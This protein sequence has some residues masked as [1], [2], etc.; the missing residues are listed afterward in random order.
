MA[1]KGTL[2]LASDFNAL[3]SNVASVLGAGSGTYGYGQSVTSSQVSTNGRITVAQWANLRNDLLKCVQHQTNVDYTGT[4]TSPTTSTKLTSTIY[5]SYKTVSDYIGPNR[6]TLPAGQATRA[7]LN[8]AQRTASWNGTISHVVVVNFTESTLYPGNYNSRFFFNAG[9]KIE[10]TVTKTT[11]SGGSKNQSWDAL[12]SSIGTI[13]FD[14][15]TTTVSGSGTGSTIGFYDLTTAYQ[16]IY[17][18]A[19]GVSESYY[20]NKYYIQAKVDNTTTRAQITFNIVFADDSGQPNP[21]WGTDESVDG[22]LTSTVQ[23]YRAT[24]T[25]VSVTQPTS[26]A[27]SL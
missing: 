21:P 7:T 12:L 6:L 27:S 23:T 11:G 9:G 4:I 1:G 20:P 18:R 14:Y 8:A 26:P 17:S 24:G 13:T 19:L 16:T 5:D 3:Q 2:I 10:F 15:D 25:N 22:T